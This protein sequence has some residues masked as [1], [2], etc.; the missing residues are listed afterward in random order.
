MPASELDP[1][2]EAFCAKLLDGATQAIRLTKVL[3]NLELKRIAGAVMDA[4][5]AYE[6]LTVRSADHREAVAALREKRTPR[7]TGR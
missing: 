1:A 7:F 3:T 6:S 5:I 2:V 4:G